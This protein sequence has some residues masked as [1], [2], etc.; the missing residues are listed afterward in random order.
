MR[1]IVRFLTALVVGAIGFGLCAAALAVAVIPIKN[2]VSVTPPELKKLS[3]LEER[4]ILYDKSGVEI[5]RIGLVN[6]FSVQLAEVPTVMIGALLATEDRSFYKNPGF[7]WRGTFRATLNNLDQGQQQGGSTITQQL[8]KNRIMK[9]KKRTS[10][11]KAREVVLAIQLNNRYPKADI[12]EEYLNT[13]YFGEN[14][15]GIGSAAERFFGLEGVQDLTLAQSALLAGV[16]RSPTANNPWNHPD[17][18][19]TRRSEVLGSMVA[20]G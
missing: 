17:Q 2:T 14:S 8:V 13:A 10:K 11:T 7:D 5:G 3:Q 15:Y 12:L 4:T 20:A 19:R 1:A 6:R 16:I 9:V 18:A